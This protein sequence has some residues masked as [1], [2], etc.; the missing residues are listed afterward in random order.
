MSNI[1]VIAI[2]I[3]HEYHS[4]KSIDIF[5][6]FAMILIAIMLVAHDLLYLSIV[7][8]TDITSIIAMICYENHLN[9]LLR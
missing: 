9:D 1:C 3:Q 2:E 7:Y 5:G 8:D 6:D 4:S